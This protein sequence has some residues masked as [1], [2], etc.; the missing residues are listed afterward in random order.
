MRINRVFLDVDMRCSFAGLRA[1][2]QSAKSQAGPGTSLL[3]INRKATQFKLLHQNKYV[4]CFNNGNRRIPLDAL[5]FLPQS[6]TGTELEMREAI[7]RSLE[8]KLLPAV[9]NAPKPD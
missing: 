4:V 2:A 8:T 7:Q 3:F 6:F 1:I 5:R 9:L